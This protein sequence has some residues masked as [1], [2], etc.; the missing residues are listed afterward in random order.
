[1]SRSSSSFEKEQKTSFHGVWMSG[2]GKICSDLFIC[3]VASFIHRDLLRKF[4]IIFKGEPNIVTSNVSQISRNNDMEEC[5]S[6]LLEYIT[7]LLTGD[8]VDLIILDGEMLP[9]MKSIF[10]L[11]ISYQNVKMIT[12]TTFNW[13]GEIPG[14]GRVKAAKLNLFTMGSWSEEDYKSAKDAGTFTSSRR[15]SMNLIKS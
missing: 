8:K 12:C 14:D 6:M 10:L 11:L 13:A 5:Y 3:Y 9:L 15:P 7:E 2:C 4:S 1:M